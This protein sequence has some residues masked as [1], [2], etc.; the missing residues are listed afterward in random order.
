MPLA[1]WLFASVSSVTGASI[2]HS[3]ALQWQTASDTSARKSSTTSS[4]QRQ[5]YTEHDTTALTVPPLFSPHLHPLSVSASQ[6]T[7]DPLVDKHGVKQ[8]RLNVP[9]VKYWIAVGAQPSDTM[10]R[11]LAQFNLLPLPPRRSQEPANAALLRGMAGRGGQDEVKGE[12]EGKEGKQVR[13]SWLYQSP[14]SHHSAQQQLLAGSATSAV[15]EH[16]QE[17]PD[18]LK[19]FPFSFVPSSST[20]T[21]W[22]QSRLRWTNSATRA[23]A[24]QTASAEGSTAT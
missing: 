3:T 1:V 10:K 24:S 6:G 4:A 11:I 7:Y 21:A 8:L 13:A 12:D 17:K 19:K 5:T 23:G 16:G 15:D 9:R 14:H 18:P 20:L 2:G 22:Q